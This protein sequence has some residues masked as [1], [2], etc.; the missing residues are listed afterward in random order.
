METPNAT[1]GLAGELSDARPKEEAPGSKIFGPSKYVAISI[2][3]GSSSEVSFSYEHYYFGVYVRAPHF[4]KLSCRIVA[5][6]ALLLKQL[7]AIILHTFGVQV[8]PTVP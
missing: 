2:N 3:W 7:L 4:W 6:G 5:F 1:Q 8:D